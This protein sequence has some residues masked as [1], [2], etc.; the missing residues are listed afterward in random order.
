MAAAAQDVSVV[1][2][3]IIVDRIFDVAEEFDLKRIESDLKGPDE[4]AR[5]KIARSTGHALILRHAPLALALGPL[6]CVPL[7]SSTRDAAEES[8]LGRPAVLRGQCVEHLVE[9][10]SREPVPANHHSTR[11][12]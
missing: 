2:G 7:Y 4:S 5:L 8:D 1:R 6:S 9:R 3:T 12:T 10:H 11:L